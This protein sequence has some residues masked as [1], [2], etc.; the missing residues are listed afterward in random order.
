MG[1][2]AHQRLLTSERVPGLSRGVFCVILRLA[3]LIRTLPAYDRHK[4]TEKKE[5]KK[6]LM[7][8][9]MTHYRNHLPT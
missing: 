6:T 2:R 1:D 9:S 8:G 3:V 5:K 7:L 4:R